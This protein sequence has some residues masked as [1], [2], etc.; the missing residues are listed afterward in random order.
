[1]AK[2]HR[3]KVGTYHPAPGTGPWY[4]IAQCTICGWHGERYEGERLDVVAR[5]KADA[6]GHGCYDARTQ[7]R[8]H[9]CTWQ[10]PA[11]P[12]WA[13]HDS[14]GYIDGG[15]PCDECGACDCSPHHEDETDEGNCIGLSF[16]YVCLDGGDNLCEACARKAGIEVVECDCP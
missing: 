8:A 15:S 4:S 14:R 5:S 6:G 12:A 10:D 9:T 13:V 1:M 7:E 2:I 11:S 3:S 16:S